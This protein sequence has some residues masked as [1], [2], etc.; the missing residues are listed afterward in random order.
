MTFTRNYCVRDKLRTFRYVHPWMVNYS[1]VN[2]KYAAIF[3]EKEPTKSRWLMTMRNA[4]VVYLNRRFIPFAMKRASSTVSMFENVKFY[5]I[6]ISPQKRGKKK[7]LKH[8]KNED[9]RK[10]HLWF[11]SGRYKSPIICSFVWILL[12]K[13]TYA[14]RNLLLNILRCHHIK[15]RF[16]C[17]CCC[18]LGEGKIKYGTRLMVVVRFLTFRLID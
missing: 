13:F 10:F 18:L 6:K 4:Y 8:P 9:K 7:T 11:A 17:C 14:F 1:D 5:F 3:H 12:C 16:C 2:N 15:Y